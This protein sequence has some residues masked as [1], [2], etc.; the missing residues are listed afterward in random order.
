M[1]ACLSENSLVSYVEGQADHATSQKIGEHLDHCPQCRALIAG[2]AASCFRSLGPLEAESTS[3]DAEPGAQGAGSP[4]GAVPPHHSLMHDPPHRSGSM[5]VTSQWP[6][7][8]RSGAL[9]AEDPLV[10]QSIG[11]YRVLALLSRGAD[12]KVYKAM[13][14]HL[15]R[16]AAVKVLQRDR[17][18][19]REIAQRFFNEALAANVIQHPGLVGVFDAGYLPSGCAFLIMEYLEGETLGMYMSRERRLPEIPALLIVHQ[20]AAALVPLHAQDIVHRDLKLGNVMLIAEPDLA[21]GKR[22]KVLDFGLAKIPARHQLEPVETRAGVAI[23]TPP[24]TAP[25]QWIAANKVDGKA[26]VYSLGVMLYLMLTGQYPYTAASVR[27]YQ[28]QH[29]YSDIPHAMAVASRVGAQANHITR[30]MLAKK[31]SERPSMADV[32]ASVDEELARRGALSAAGH[33]RL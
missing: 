24:Y 13:H 18:A 12:A 11:N 5:G 21:G 20:I 32:L 26:D 23:G 14:Q 10:G 9:A 25:E 30:R 3:G 16:P 27:E 15:R 22:V 31:R 2:M 8:D 19:Q 28:E 6:A 29:L 7:G 17:S 33:L 4:A 1:S